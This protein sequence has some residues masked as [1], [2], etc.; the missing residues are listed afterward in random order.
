MYISI[1]DNVKYSI[2]S[3]FADE[4]NRFGTLCTSIQC[5]SVTDTC[6][7]MPNF[8]FAHFPIHLYT[9]IMALG[10]IA[11]A[12]WG[13]KHDNFSV[14]FCFKWKSKQSTK[15]QKCDNL[16]ITLPFAISIKFEI[17][18]AIKC[19]ILN[20]NLVAVNHSAPQFRICPMCVCV[21]V[22]A[23]SLVL[24]RKFTTNAKK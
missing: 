24:D 17:C 21:C 16:W 5:H 1:D 2:L 15:K 22:V 10:D 11:F 3:L 9:S 6:L 23:A 4:F 20:N 7:R 19:L 18:A 14:C 13:N 8:L 12:V